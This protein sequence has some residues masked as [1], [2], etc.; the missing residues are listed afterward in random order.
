[1]A[2]YPE[3]H[4]RATCPTVRR[5][6]FYPDYVGIDQPQGASPKTLDRHFAGSISR[7]S[8]PARFAT[9]ATRPMTPTTPT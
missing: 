7:P 9:A 5:I 1:M 6:D 4:R 3:L 2:Y 8:P